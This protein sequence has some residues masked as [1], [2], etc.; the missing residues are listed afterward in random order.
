MKAEL[1]CCVDGRLR[2]R[3]KVGRKVGLQSAAITEYLIALHCCGL[4]F[5]IPL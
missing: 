3:E 4:G 2:P 5:L 1:P